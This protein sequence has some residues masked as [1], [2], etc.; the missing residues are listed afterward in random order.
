VVQVFC[1]LLVL[2]IDWEQGSA[3]T[4]PL[5]GET[6]SE[7]RVLC[8]GKS[9]GRKRENIQMPQGKHPAQSI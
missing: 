4:F 6:I 9:P 2:V 7:C 5:E 1:P 8:I 3:Q